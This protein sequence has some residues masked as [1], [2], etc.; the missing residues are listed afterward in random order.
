[1]RIPRVLSW[2]LLASA[3]AAC[4]SRAP[5]AD[6]APAA[7]SAVASHDSS[8]GQTVVDDSLCAT[9]PG[10]LRV[11]I[12]S[13][14]GMPADASIR[15]LRNRCAKVREDVYGIGGSS[16]AA[17]VFPFRGGRVWAVQTNVEGAVDTTRSIDLWAAEGDSLVMP[18]RSPMPR[19][20]GELRTRYPA[21]FVIADKGDDADGVLAFACPFPRLVMALSE[22][23]ATPADTG[24]WALARR[25]VSDTVTIHRVEVWAAAQAER[26]T[27][28][29]T[30]EAS[31]SPAGR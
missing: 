30:A 27:E 11:A 10:G 29:C 8:A 25:A 3:S 31:S 28:L 12:D 18:D 15:Y 21:G 23:A 7:A 13:M 17:L 16:A 6:R 26:H 19:T 1:M 24:H 4:D 2:L 5:D 22:D 20:I 14:A 9:P